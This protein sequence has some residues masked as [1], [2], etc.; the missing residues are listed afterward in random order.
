MPK[1]MPEPV[2]TFANVC[3]RYQNTQILDRVSFSIHAGEVIGVIGPN[4]EGKTTTL[5]LA[6]GFLKPSEG[7]ISIKNVPPSQGRSF[8][9]YVPQMHPY[10]RQ[11]P[12]SAFEVILTGAISKISWLGRFPKSVKARADRLV[13]ELQLRPFIKKSFG[14][15]SGGQAQKVLLARALITDPAILLLDEPTAHID[16]AAEE[17]I[18]T[19]LQTLAPAKTLVI[20][21]HN[22]DAILRYTHRVL[23]FQ[24]KVS[25][26]NPKE[27]CEHFALGMYHPPKTSP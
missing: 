24:K 8:I 16:P 14:S 6:M 20:V 19:F 1:A 3:F 9:G 22:F 11:F 26:L 27:V 18:F 21:T 12:I 23:C 4:G 15:L 5:R 25:S 2:I 7:T 10:D 13:E 17:T